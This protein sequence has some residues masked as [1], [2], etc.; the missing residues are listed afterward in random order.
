[1]QAARALDTSWFRNVVGRFIV[2]TGYSQNVR[3]EEIAEFYD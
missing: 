3:K 1:V 2:D